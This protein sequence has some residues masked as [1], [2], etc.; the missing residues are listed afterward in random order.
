MKKIVLLSILCCASVLFAAKGPNHKSLRAYSMGNA[1]IAVVD[2]KEAIY[3][4]WRV[5]LWGEGDGLQTYRRRNVTVEI[6]DNHLRANKDPLN[7]NT[8]RVYT[9]EIPSSEM[10][11]NPYISTTEM[12][13]KVNRR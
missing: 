9:Y 3:Y 7:P 13:V 12:A 2:D 11:Y 10:N 4:N 8:E 5:E 6:G 1:H